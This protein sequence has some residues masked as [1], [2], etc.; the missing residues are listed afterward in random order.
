MPH[1]VDNV[2]RPG[3]VPTPPSAKQHVAEKRF[4]DN[5]V[6]EVIVTRW[7]FQI[8]V[9][10]PLPGVM[11]QFDKYVW[12]LLE[13]VMSWW[14]SN[15]WIHGWSF[16]KKTWPWTPHFLHCS[17]KEIQVGLPNTF[18]TA[19]LVLHDHQ[20]EGAPGWWKIDGLKGDLWKRDPPDMETQQNY[21]EMIL[22]I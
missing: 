7:W 1:D 21:V 14:Y 22:V 13:T 3:H 20:Q 2:Q 9:F 12:D 6:V 4:D 16:I 17:P 8:C 11:I 10:S 5:V 19:T 15:L 18:V